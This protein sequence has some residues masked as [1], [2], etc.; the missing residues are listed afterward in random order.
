MR[1]PPDLTY[2]RKPK[3]VVDLDKPFGIIHASSDRY[4]NLCS[5]KFFGSDIDDLVGRIGEDIEWCLGCRPGALP[6][7][8]I[9]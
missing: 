7:R 5:M 4:G 1:S 2:S 3:K 6:G 9:E 8:L